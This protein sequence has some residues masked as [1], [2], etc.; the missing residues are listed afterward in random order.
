MEELLKS[1]ATD[2]WRRRVNVLLESPGAKQKM[3]F[4]SFVIAL[5]AT[6]MYQLHS[7]DLAHCGMH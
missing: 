2:L 6:G 5:L 7:H 4:G 3:P 1:A